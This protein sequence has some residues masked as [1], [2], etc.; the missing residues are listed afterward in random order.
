MTANV[1]L[2][3]KMQKL[4]ELF[5]VEFLLPPQSNECTAELYICGVYMAGSVCVVVAATTDSVCG[6]IN[7]KIEPKITIKIQNA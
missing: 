3:Q 4:I 7:T 1:K 5:S 6:K 2:T